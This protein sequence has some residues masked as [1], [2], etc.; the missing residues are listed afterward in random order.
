LS[1][2]DSWHQ[3]PAAAAAEREWDVAIVG[4]G[5]AG[6][7]AAIHLASQ[8]HKVLLVDK[9]G[10]PRDKICGDGLIA[11]TIRSLK[12][13]GLYESV[14]E[15]G[16]KIAVGTVYSPSQV[17]FDI[18]GE[19]LTLKRVILD[20]II[21]RRAVA[22]GARFCRCKVVDITTQPD[23]RLLISISDSPEKIRARIVC[24]ATG[25]NVEMPTKLGLVS[26][27]R[28]SA[29]ALR[30]Y[31]RSPV[32]VDRLI[33]SYDKSITPGYAWIFPLG[34]G[35]F[36]V[37]CGIFYRKTLRPKA[38]LREVFESFVSNFPLARDIMRHA[39][40]I[41]PLS[42][43]MLR[44]GLSGAH[45]VGPGSILTLGETIG[46]TFPFTG[47][48]IGK[49]METGEMA[50]E[51]IDQAI[52]TGNLA[53]LEDFPRRLEHELKPKFIGYLIAESWFTRPWLTDFVAKRIR[54]SRVLQ[55]LVAGIVNETVDPRE[56]FSLR[57]ILR[58]FVS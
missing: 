37:G 33:V 36:N 54:N 4:A 55:E 28:P 22:A 49:A 42:G 45:P 43:A 34:N 12:R 51:I 16:N 50:A 41:T 10:F 23:G 5:P 2:N 29:V 3:I 38:N 52:S 39:E 20:A 18:P 19:F 47:E 44:C 56:V 57:G 1:D 26:Q 14:R 7:T 21:A 15:L 58:S 27:N 31:V 13:L 17:H 6:S 35:E 8:G 46:T 25:A 48:G 9:D 30:C 53:L 24:L 40:S 11:D 32:E